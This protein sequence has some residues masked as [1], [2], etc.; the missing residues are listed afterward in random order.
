MWDRLRIYLLGGFR[1]EHRGLDIERFRT[2]KT[3]SLLAYLAFHDRHAIPREVLID[4][5]WP[6]D[7][8]EKARASLN[9]AIYSLR[10]HIGTVSTLPE[11][12]LLADRHTVRLNRNL[13]W[14]D[15]EAFRRA[16]KAA[17]GPEESRAAA[18]EEALALYRGDLLSGFYDEWILN[19]AIELQELFESLQDLLPTQG[20]APHVSA[21]EI[22]ERQYGNLP[23]IGNLFVGREPELLQLQEL[24]ASFPLVSVVG[25]GGVGKTRLVIEFC[26]KLRQ[27]GSQLFWISFA[28]SAADVSVTEEILRQL[29]ISPDPSFDPLEQLSVRLGTAPSTL[30]LDNLEHV[31]GVERHLPILLD[32][33]QTSHFITTTRVRLHL[34]TEAVLPLEPL[35]VPSSGENVESLRSNPSAA[36]FL[37]RCALTAPG[38][39]LG[40]H[41][42]EAVGQLCQKLEGI[43]LMIELAAARVHVFSVREMLDQMDRPLEFLTRVKDRTGRHRSVRAAI[44]WSYRILSP[45]AKALFPKLSLARGGWTFSSASKVLPADGLGD[46]I[47]E[48]IDASMLR[49]SLSKDSR[50][51]TMHAVLREF[52]LELLSPD[53][54]ADVQDRRLAHL[55]ELASSAGATRRGP[56]PKHWLEAIEEEFDNIRDC[57]E[58][59]WENGREAPAAELATC[60]SLFLERR[61]RFQEGLV[62]VDRAVQSTALPAPLRARALLVSGVLLRLANDCATA[63]ERHQEAA[64]LFGQLGDRVQLAD[65]WLCMGNLRA[66]EGDFDGAERFFLKSLNECEQ[67]GIPPGPGLLLNL[68]MVAFDLGRFEVADELCAKALSVAQVQHDTFMVGRILVHQGDVLLRRGLDRQAQLILEECISIYRDL[69]DPLWLAVART[70]LARLHYRRGEYHEASNQC[71]LALRTAEEVGEL[72]FWGAIQA[73]RGKILLRQGDAKG[74][75]ALFQQ[76]VGIGRRIKDPR[77]SAEVGALLASIIYPRDRPE[78]VR[79]LSNSLQLLEGDFHS[80]EIHDVFLIVAE[81]ALNAGDW[82]AAAELTAAS[83]AFFKDH[84]ILPDPISASRIDR[85]LHLPER[86]LSS[87]EAW[88]LAVE[89]LAR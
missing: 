43:S 36:L 86:A 38:F 11:P 32:R 35:Q 6:E 1:V 64:S 47:Q 20:S 19:P 41:N 72:R 48:L 12:F 25:P 56:R 89:I 49:C 26:K 78:A 77:M 42:A 23:R 30:I 61:G 37:S 87:S 44:D 7:P 8:P 80:D 57:L 76:S 69:G 40:P 13:I 39:S 53:Q 21:D 75:E 83:R 50:R 10:R 65:V 60:L 85:D 55:I 59:A 54:V 5:F 34:Q 27:I 45:S 15:V 46:T 68:G 14:T 81:L 31:S 4:Q 71:D 28:G 22:N 70:S 66:T 24:H 79:L 3:A 67:A 82:H 16:A 88:S 58:W 63:F 52:G 51:F 17:A 18:L 84:G 29:G 33:L 74:A 2:K 9:T 73:W 62:W